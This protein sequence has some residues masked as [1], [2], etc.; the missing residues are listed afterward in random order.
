MVD[1]DGVDEGRGVDVFSAGADDAA[2]LCSGIGSDDEA[3]AC[4]ATPQDLTSSAMAMAR[5]TKITTHTA[6]VFLLFIPHP[7]INQTNESVVVC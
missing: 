1:G 7:P 6:T 4:S 2:A 3:S 5:M